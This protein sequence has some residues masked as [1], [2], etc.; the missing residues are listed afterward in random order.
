MLLCAA[1][2][3]LPV[4]AMPTAPMVG[5]PERSAVQVGTLRVVLISYCPG[6]GDSL[7]RQSR[8]GFN[9][10]PGF[11]CRNAQGAMYC[12][13]AVDIPTGVI[14]ESLPICYV[15]SLFATE[16]RHL[17]SAPCIPAQGVDIKEFSDTTYERIGHTA[18][19][20]CH[21]QTA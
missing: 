11:S 17:R 19:I 21:A 10:I 20:Y 18:E 4:G 8:D 14:R 1:A 9:S 13:T 15:L 3:G 6:P 7:K 2:F 16:N 12:F 5:L